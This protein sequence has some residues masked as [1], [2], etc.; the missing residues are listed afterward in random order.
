MNTAIRTLLCG[1]FFSSI[2]SAYATQP[3]FSLTPLTRTEF[4]VALDETV[5]VRYR[6]LNNTDV[7]RTLTMVPIDGITQMTLGSNNCSNPFVLA[8]GQ[9]CLLTLSLFGGELPPRINTGPRICKTQPNTNTP[10]PFLCSQPSRLD[11]LNIIRAEEKRPI[12]FTNTSLLPLK[13]GGQPGNLT[14]TNG[15]P[16]MTAYNVKADLSGTALGFNVTQDSSDCETVL[17]DETC[18]LTFTPNSNA[19]SL[20]AVP[21][22]GDNTRIIGSAI[23]VAEPETSALIG[24]TNSPLILTANAVGSLTIKNNSQTLSASGIQAHSMPAGITQDASNCTNT[25]IPPGGTCTLSFTASAFG[26]PAFT[27]LIYGNDTSQTQ[28]VLAVDAPPL[29]DIAFVGD[30]SLTLRAD[31]T[32]TGT[33]TIQNTSGKTIDAGVTAHFEGTNL[34][35]NVAATECPAMNNGDTCNITFTAGRTSVPTA[36]TFPIYKTDTTTTLTGTLTINPSPVAYLSSTRYND[37]YQCVIEA[38]TNNFTQCQ[39]FS[40]LG[41]NTPRGIAI[42]PDKT[43]AYIVNN[44]DNSVS[45]CDIEDNTHYLTNCQNANANGLNSPVGIAINPA[46]TNAYITNKGS[47]TVSRCPIQADGGF[48]ATCVDSG[49]TLLSQPRDI[50]LKIDNSFAYIANFTSKQIIQCTIGNDNNLLSCLVVYQGVGEEWNGIAIN[51]IKG[52]LYSA[53]FNYN[54]FLTCALIDGGGLGDCIASGMYP[55]VLRSAGVAVNSLGT[56]SYIANSENTYYAQCPLQISG[57]VQSCSKI[58]TAPP[59][60]WG[61]ALLE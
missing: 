44:G 2:A 3:K 11:S 33:M 42:N 32:N 28:A 5:T 60:L 49:A 18:T 1:L 47:N 56:I 51:S 9:S 29:L 12:L 41:V 17:P 50:A 54:T 7:T 6:V 37:I 45:R 59:Y 55:S 52:R 57:N 40:N 24:V 38:N 27:T 31:G 22:R 8:P 13:A 46:G 25:P 23:V 61:I 10:D 35:G 53:D 26:V 15:S 20:T 19:V 14:I 16:I 43:R 39:T 34:S 4:L 48:A 30:S 36:T 58:Y 21:I